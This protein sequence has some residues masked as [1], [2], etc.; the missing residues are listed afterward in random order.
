MERQTVTLGIVYWYCCRGPCYYIYQIPLEDLSTK[1]IH[2]LSLATMNGNASVWNTELFTCINKLLGRKYQRMYFSNVGLSNAD[3][4][5][6]VGYQGQNEY[7][8]ATYRL[9]RYVC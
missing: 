8:Y 2:L 5:Y 3:L 6:D 7:L 4:E 9:S 1:D